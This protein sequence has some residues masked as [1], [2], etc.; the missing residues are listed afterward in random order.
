MNDES[1]G[2][3]QYPGLRGDVIVALE[4]FATL[5]PQTVEQ[6]GGA[7]TDA[8]HWLVDDT[9]WDLR[10][11]SEDIG[12]RLRDGEEVAAIKAVLEPLLAVLGQL[13]P[14]RPD[15]EYLAHRRWSDVM[16]NAGAAH[17]L[18]VANDAQSR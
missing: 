14:V 8:V 15:V 6:Q 7:L 2:E 13:G 5:T 12:Y 1:P 16:A 18:L 3:V 10:D 17:R 4:R 9:F 11:P